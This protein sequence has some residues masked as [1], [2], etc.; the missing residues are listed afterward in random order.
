MKLEKIKLR[1][2]KPGKNSRAGAE[3]D[4]SS[5]MSSIKE[6]GLLQPIGVIKKKEGHF[7]ICFGNRRFWASKKLGYND[8][9]AIVYELDSI[10]EII[11]NLSENIHR[12][13]VSY[14][15]IAS[16][17]NGLHELYSLSY[18]EIA[19][20]M[21][22]SEANIRD[23]IKAIGSI[24]SNILKNTYNLVP[25]EKRKG[26][27]PKTAVVLVNNL[28]SRHHLKKED[29]EL[30][31]AEIK[32]NDSFSSQD[33]R[34][35]GILMGMGMSFKKAFKDCRNIV[36]VRPDI[37]LYKKDYEIIKEKFGT[38]RSSLKTLVYN[39]NLIKIKDPFKK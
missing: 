33:I 35:I 31:F 6:V 1:N 3:K 38:K 24:N 9:D 32:R 11:Y 14:F 21:S 17:V 36:L 15:E 16:Y 29:S 23:Y 28:I 5:L 26:K 20:R 7:S 30:I 22:M 27:I 18:S 39:N 25:G 13:D 2:I 4:L 34:T 37:P 10:E 19:V 8:I 12:K